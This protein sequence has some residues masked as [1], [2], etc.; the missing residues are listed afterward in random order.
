MT[1]ILKINVR[2]LSEA[3]VQDLIAHYGNAELEIRV[4]ST[5]DRDEVMEEEEFWALIA[6]LD[7]SESGRNDQ[8]LEPLVAALSQLPVSKIYQFYD[9]LSEK[10]WRLDT[11]AHG[12]A[13]VRGAS[14]DYFS[15]DEFL[16]ARCCVVANGQEAYQEVLADPS[17]F[18]TELA[19]EDLLYAASD[20]YE[21]KTG[22][23]FQ[24]VPA[25]DFE[26][27]GNEEGWQ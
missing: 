15:D 9:I 17:K 2:N 22:K 8:I 10:L 3:V 18:P 23:K 24:S 14:D 26:T 19:F 5:P 4:R 13:M 1:R 20:A 11:R 21:R 12:E 27:G 6:R 7:W 16:Y 25:Y